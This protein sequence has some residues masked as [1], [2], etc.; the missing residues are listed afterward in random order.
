MKIDSRYNRFIFC[1]N[2]DLRKRCF[3]I[4]RPIIS[5]APAADG[6]PAAAVA[7]AAGGDPAA[8]ATVAAGGCPAAVAV[9]HLSV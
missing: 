4:R 2:V 7:S 8:A 5:T 1:S 6:A 9:R 3:L